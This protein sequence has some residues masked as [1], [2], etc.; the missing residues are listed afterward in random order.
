MVSAHFVKVKQR[1]RELFFFLKRV[2]HE[3]KIKFGEW[4]KENKY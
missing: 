1:M 4:R 3:E 2:E